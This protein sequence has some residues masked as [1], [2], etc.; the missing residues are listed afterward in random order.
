MGELSAG[1]VIKNFSQYFI[2]GPLLGIFVAFFADSWTKRI[3]GDDIGILWITYVLVYLT[4]YWAEFG[5]LHTSGLL[6]VIALG[7][8][9]NVSCKN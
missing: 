4:F 2:V 1:G 8:F 7:L 5:F 6:A 9:R 3:I